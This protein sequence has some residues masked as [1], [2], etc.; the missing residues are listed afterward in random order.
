MIFI[1]YVLI[2]YLFIL[3]YLNL[4][5]SCMPMLLINLVQCRPPQD[6]DVDWRVSV[7]YILDAFGWWPS[8]I[9]G[10][11]FRPSAQSSQSSVID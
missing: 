10:E 7:E 8:H 5:L 9:E 4:A 3:I 6:S 1:D 11:G 2:I